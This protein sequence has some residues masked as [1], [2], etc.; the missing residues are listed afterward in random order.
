MDMEFLLGDENI[1]ELGRCISPRKMEIG[2]TV[3]DRTKC[4]WIFHFKMANWYY[5]NL[6]SFKNRTKKKKYPHKNLNP[7]STEVLTSR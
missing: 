5:I 4:H 6:I 3:F 7:F 1:L 2:S